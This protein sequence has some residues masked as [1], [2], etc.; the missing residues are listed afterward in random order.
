MRNDQKE[1]AGEIE[2]AEVRE[3][4]F[5]PM[6]GESVWLELKLRS[7]SKQRAASSTQVTF[8]VGQEYHRVLT[9]EEGWAR[10]VFHAEQAEEAIVIATVPSVNGGLAATPT[11]TFRFRVLAA[12]V[13]DDARLKLNDGPPTVVGVETLFPRLV[14]HTVHLSIANP[15]SPLLGREVCLGL[16]GYSSATDLG[17]TVEPALG[18]YRPLPTEGLSWQCTGSIGGAYALQVAASRML[19]RSPGNPMSLGATQD[20]G[21]PSIVGD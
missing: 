18:V 2:I 6:V 12:G 20:S 1:A 10:F 3:A 19:K 5:D 16:S 9:D 13:W 8:A 14:D 15:E 11:H 21:L 7:S 4:S 17:L